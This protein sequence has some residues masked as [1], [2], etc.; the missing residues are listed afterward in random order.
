MRWQVLDQSY[1]PT[2]GIRRS[3]SAPAPAVPGS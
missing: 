2:S 3:T 1:D